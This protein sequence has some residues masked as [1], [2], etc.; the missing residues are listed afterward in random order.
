MKGAQEGI[1]LCKKHMQERAR[2]RSPIPAVSTS[3]IKGRKS[4]AHF[5]EEEKEEKR[6]KPRSAS[7]DPVPSIAMLST[8]FSG[9]PALLELRLQLTDGEKGRCF[10]LGLA[11]EAA[12]DSRRTERAEVEVPT[13]GCKLSTPWPKVEH[14]HHIPGGKLP[15][16]W[17]QRHL[18]QIPQE[19]EEGGA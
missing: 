9:F 17:S 6:V 10:M 8:Q 16:E 7:A 18:K 4:S 13:L 11:K 1:P 14:P 5:G 15:K 12:S 3:S 19:A 2:S